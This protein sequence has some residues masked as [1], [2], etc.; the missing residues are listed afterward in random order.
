MQSPCNPRSAPHKRSADDHHH[1]SRRP[2]SWAAHRRRQVQCALG[3]LPQV[4]RLPTPAATASQRGVRLD[5]ESW[6]AAPRSGGDEKWLA[7]AQTFKS[8]FGPNDVWLADYVES[9]L[10]RTFVLVGCGLWWTEV[11]LSGHSFPTYSPRQAECGEW[12]PNRARPPMS[13]GQ[14]CRPLRSVTGGPLRG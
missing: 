5:P 6:A 10:A 9:R 11:A 2:P 1:K 7:A 12:S 3:R 8:S 13:T 14:S 4:G